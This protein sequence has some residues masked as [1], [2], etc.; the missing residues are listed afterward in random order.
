MNIE[1]SDILD[2][3]VNRENFKIGYE[4]ERNTYMLVT[5]IGYFILDDVLNEKI[6]YA[7]NYFKEK[8]KFKNIIDLILE[9]KGSLN[10]Y[11]GVEDKELD[12]YLYRS[13]DIMKNAVDFAIF[14]S[15]M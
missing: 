15:Q 7:V 14:D 2:L 11:T 1:F 3:K 5:E 12:E 10:L 4:H 6:D 13:K 8:Y 9:P